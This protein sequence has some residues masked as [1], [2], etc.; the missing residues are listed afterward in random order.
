[1]K[2]CKFL[3]H[4]GVDRLLKAALGDQL[5][6][7]RDDRDGMGWLDGDI[8]YEEPPSEEL[9]DVVI[10]DDRVTWDFIQE[11]KIKY[12]EVVWYVHGTYTRWKGF[13]D[14]ANQVFRKVHMLATDP[15]REAAILDWYRHKPISRTF[16]PLHLTDDYF[17][18]LATKKNG[19]CCMVGNR[20]LKACYIYSDHSVLANVFK[21]IDAS[22]LDVFG[23]N[24]HPDD[25]LNRGCQIPKQSVRGPA[26]IREL[27]EYSVSIHPS[28]VPTL[29]FVP[30]ELMA[31]GVP[32]VLTPKVDFPESSDSFFIARSSDDFINY[33]NRLLNDKELSLEKGRLGQQFLKQNFPFSNYKERLV[34]W[35]E[36]VA[37]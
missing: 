13:Q 3:C 5:T 14:F 4:R 17:V 20:L 27:G 32:M 12:K 23:W 37:S 8:D 18:D 30:L 10:V 22:R 34:K 9:W 35:L 11:Y 19:R 7:F 31:I 29:G 6:L 25:Q 26:K 16:L 24:D 33:T 2:I 28:F 21:R 1:M 15:A 36:S